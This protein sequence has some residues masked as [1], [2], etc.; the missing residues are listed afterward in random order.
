MGNDCLRRDRGAWGDDAGTGEGPNATVAGNGTGTDPAQFL[1]QIAQKMAE[2]NER[3]KN[4][5]ESNEKN[6]QIM[7][8]TNESLKKVVAELNESRKENRQKA[9][10]VEE[11]ERKVDGMYFIRT[12][13][14][15][16]KSRINVKLLLAEEGM[17]AVKLIS[18]KIEKAN[19]PFLKCCRMPPPNETGDDEWGEVMD[20]PNPG[21][22][23]ENMKRRLHNESNL[24]AKTRN[25]FGTKAKPHEK[26]GGATYVTLAHA[27]PRDLACSMFWPYFLPLLTGQ[28]E[29][30][31]WQRFCAV[32]G[33]LR[34]EGKGEGGCYKDEDGCYQYDHDYKYQGVK[35]VLQNLLALPP[36]H[37]KY[38]GA[39]G[40]GN[41]LIIPIIDLQSEDIGGQYGIKSHYDLLVLGRSETV[42]SWIYNGCQPPPR[43]L[44]SKY[45]DEGVTEA[46]LEDVRVATEFLAT[47]VA[48]ATY[49]GLTTLRDDLPQKEQEAA[50]PK[51]FGSTSDGDE[52]DEEEPK[53]E[54]DEEDPKKSRELLALGSR[55][56]NF[57]NDSCGFHQQR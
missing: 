45:F 20:V 12:S 17:A 41:L 29:G 5:A 53:E 11:R 13:E 15:W 50:T 1:Q 2:T 14:L 43:H 16:M 9:E 51:R 33:L 54:V 22:T 27:A 36:D 8:E 25:I 21:S 42:Y 49:L 56:K 23:L 38:F 37:G 34:E 52:V 47:Y 31:K 6:G 10:I 26:D 32:H 40:S 28:M 39:S 48:A 46:T 44:S 19:G 57:R 18:E 3:L 4:M 55:R 35:N 30:S 24:E 7:A